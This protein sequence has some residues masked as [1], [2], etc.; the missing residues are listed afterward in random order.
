MT[1]RP[2]VLA[3]G[4]KPVIA[5]DID[6]TLGDYHGHVIRFAKQWV[7]GIDEI[8]ETCT[9]ESLREHLGMSRPKY[10]Q[11]KLAYRQ[12]GLK[13]A[14]PCF[15]GSSELCRSL[16]RAG[17]EIWICTTRPYL[18]LDNIDPDTRE[19]LRRNRIPYDGVL[20]DP[21]KY[22][23]LRRIVGIERVVTVLDDLPEQI[24]EA[25]RLGIEPVLMERPHNDWWKWMGTA[26]VHDPYEALDLLVERLDQFRGS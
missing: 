10:R 9:R 11:M 21:H 22:S 4:D 24:E 14:M 13:R 15:P 26:R 19:W 3:N 6:G 17:A 2:R 1:A 23:Q 25:H 8:G 12:S 7:G 5:I 18:R 16:R 20:F